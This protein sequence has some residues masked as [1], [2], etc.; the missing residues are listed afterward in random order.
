MADSRGDFRRHV[1][2]DASLHEVAG[3]IS[4]QRFRG[5]FRQATGAR[6]SSPDYDTGMRRLMTVL[7][8]LLAAA[9]LLAQKPTIDASEYAA[10]RARLAKEIGPNAILVALFAEAADSQRRSGVAVPAERRSSLPHRHRRGRD[11][12]GHGSRRSRIRRGAVRARSESAAGSL[13]GTHSDARG[14]HEDQRRQADRV[15]ARRAQLREHGAVRLAVRHEFRS[16]DRAPS[17]ALD[18]A[19]LRRGA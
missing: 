6:G 16:D 7:L 3:E 5:L 9:P 1:V 8:A 15:V 2:A 10:R 11:H 12:A 19:L 4:D 14:D 13:D 18:A 17:A